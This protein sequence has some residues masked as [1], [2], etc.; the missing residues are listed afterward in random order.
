MNLARFFYHSTTLQ[1]TH[2][3]TIHFK[4]Y[5]HYKR[6]YSIWETEGQKLKVPKEI[7]TSWLDISHARSGGKGGQNV[8]KVNTKVICKFKPREVDWLSE[9]LAKNLESLY[10]EKM[11]NDGEFM[12][13]SSAERTQDANLRDCLRKLKHYLN[14]S[15]YVKK[16][17]IPTEPPDWIRE[18]AVESKR[19]HSEKKKNRQKITDYKN[20]RY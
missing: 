4:K 20:Y 3:R 1:S 7:K 15:S 11:N 2:N 13:Y 14:E 9:E 19:R 18:K 17:R 16:D 12:V 6:L 8:N 5:T 10:A